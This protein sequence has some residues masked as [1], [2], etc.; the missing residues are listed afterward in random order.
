MAS[1]WI[2]SSRAPDP[3]TVVS[4]RPSTQADPVGPLL[5]RAAE[6]DQQAFAQVY[7]ATCRAVFGIVLAVLRD[8]AQAEEVTQEVYVDAWR[9]AG[10]FDPGRGS[11][12]AWLNTIAHR[13]AVDRV[14]SQ[15]RRTARETRHASVHYTAGHAPD[16]SEVVVDKDERRR[17]HSALQT[18]PDAQQEALRLAYFE[19]RTHREIAE[20]LE[21]P[22]GTVKTRIRDATK[23][24]RTLMEEG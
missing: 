18:L 7:D 14:R 12:A 9:Q 4:V 17:V 24:L 20:V 16:A 2:R 1:G 21:V 6:G 19:G 23:K 15:E 5:S 3:G 10:G 8:R 22:L 11:A 13:R